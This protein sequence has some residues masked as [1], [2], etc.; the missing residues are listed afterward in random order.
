MSVRK[1]GYVGA[2]RGVRALVS[3]AGLAL[4]LSSG[5]DTAQAA[6]AMQPGEAYV[7]RF[8]GTTSADG[9]TVIDLKGTVGSIVDVRNPSQPPQG[10][11]WLNEPQ[12]HKITAGETG[13]VFGVALDDAASPNIFLTATSAF[14]LHR[15]SD[16]MAGMWG[17][18]GGPG[19]VW[20]LSPDTGYKPVAFATIGVDG[21]ANTGAA[22]GNI[23]YDK[24]YHQ[25]YVSDLESGLIHRLSPDGTDLGQFDQ[26][27]T[28]RASF[29]DAATGQQMSLPTVA[30]DPAT[31]AHV[32]DCKEGAFDRTPS[33]WNL[34]DFRRRVWGLGVRKDAESGQ[35]R[36]YYA[37]WSSQALGS[38]DFASASEEEKR[39]SVWSVAIKADG[40]FDPGSVRREYFLPDF[41]TD[42][43]AIA[44]S[45]RSNPVSD[46]AFCKCKDEKTMLVAE[47]GGV[48][49]LGLDAEEPFA[50]P[51]ESRVLAYELNDK[52]VWQLKGRYDIGHYDRKND[53]QAFLRVNGSGGV[54]YGFGYGVEWHIDTARPDETVWMTGGTL[55]SPHGPCFSP[56]IGRSEDGSYVAGAQGMPVRAIDKVLPDEATKPYPAAGVPYPATGPL[57]SYILDTDENLDA[58][59]NVI[60][61]E[62]TR[63]DA[64]KVGDIEIYE[65]CEKEKAEV[66]EPPLVAETPEIEE[67]PVVVENPPAPDLPDLEKVKTG[68]AQCIAGNICTFTITITNRGPGVWSGPLQE[69]DTLPP[70]A[71]LWDYR[72]QP[73]WL[74]T[75]AVGTDN[76]NCTHTWV[77]LNPG[78]A[79]TLIIDALL[80]PGVF[81][82]VENCVQDVWL[83]SRDP[84]DP[85]VILAIEQALNSFGYPVGPIDGVL[86]VVTMNSIMVLQADNGL[87]ATGVPD[88]VLID[89][90]FGGSAGLAGDSNPAN[91][92]SCHTVNVIPPPVQPAVQPSPAQPPAAPPPGAAPDIQ[93][94]KE[95]TDRQCGPGHQ[96]TFRLT[97][98]NRGPGEW[99]GVPEIIDTLPAGAT[100]EP[101]A[102][103]DGCSQAGSTVTCRYPEQ[104]TLPPNSPGSVMITVLMPDTLPAG[105]ENCAEL[106]PTAAANDPNSSNNRHCIPI[107]AASPDLQTRKLQRTARC[108]PGGLCDFELW[109]LNRGPGEWTGTPEIVDVLPQGATFV[110]ATAPAICSQSGRT[111]TCRYPRQISLA[112]GAKRRVEIT[113]RMPRNLQPGARNCVSIPDRLNPGDPDPANNRQCIPVRVAPPPVPDIHIRKF[114]ADERC[115]HGAD[116]K[117]DLWFINR[118]PGPWTGKPQLVDELPAGARLKSSPDHWKCQQSGRN[119][120]C[121]H[122]KITIPPGRGIKATVTIELPADLAPNAKNCVHNEGDGDARHDPVPHNNESC[123]TIVTTAHPEPEPAHPEEPTPAE[124]SEPHAPPPA[125][126]AE[127]HVEKKQLG[128]CRPGHACLFE[129]TFINKG[130]GTWTGKAKLSDLLPDANATLGSWSPSTWQCAQ[131]GTAI[132]CEHSGATVAPNERLSVTMSLHMPEHL[133]PGA[134]NCVVQERP[135]IGPIDPSILGDKHC[136]PIDVV[137]P[138]FT[139]RP[140]AVVQQCPEGTVRQ[141][142]QCVTITRSCPEGYVLKGDKCYSTTLTCP[143][144]YVLKGNKC[145][146]TTLTCPKGYVL[147]GKKCY[148]IQ[149]TCPPGYVLRGNRCYLIQRSCPPGFVRVGNLCIRIGGGVPH[150]QE[151]RY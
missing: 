122:D 5:V 95:Q 124:P 90:L 88:Q 60:M 145:Y 20:K 131:K 147:R 116:C 33:C 112:P 28:G 4:T 61:A 42:S 40:E 140:P 82:P 96:C 52:G 68:P 23:A 102:S 99:T 133:A 81:G 123:V 12:R 70:G 9:K 87:P 62:L 84:N 15:T 129:L 71:L 37:V 135:D 93:V 53:G 83:P 1:G 7:T 78:D 14:G 143:K 16:W 128:P 48:R 120:T 146:S 117:F 148:K 27:V 59:G 105:A 43:A 54:D 26:G 55:C 111:L 32:T 50:N 39:N 47:R 67:P 97:F 136:V 94:R 144:G 56:D 57:Q 36:L 49:N 134:Q 63:N 38:K 11:H 98:V 2:V 24:W 73:D 17:P 85:A 18:G 75:Q 113:V 66:E 8:S 121:T 13:Q 109:L 107:E 41:F 58:N 25:F 51:H 104:V 69:L 115:E 119:V 118:G 64:T 35:V 46:I 151:H 86:D 138:G 150:G 139:P 10:H 3:A 19:T 92:M 21:R 74:C 79:V 125:E 108:R 45:G 127:T 103:A 76:V 130:P 22:L 65:L 132:S 29:I 114:Q 100:L 34:A 89:Q 142:G 110:S 126:P 77:T 106:G 31:S 30:F 44:R 80:P 72:P 6:E 91:D 137:T 141:N 149:R 101:S